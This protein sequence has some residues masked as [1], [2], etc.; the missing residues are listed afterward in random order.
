MEDRHENTSKGAR[1]PSW[2]DG[3]KIDEV[4]FCSDFLGRHPMKCVH[5]RLFTV[6]GAVEDEGGISR[7]I[8]EEVSGCLSSGISK[9][10]TNLL[11]A[12][13]LTAYSP[14]LPIE[15]DRIHVANGTYFLNGSFTE[16]KA[17][18]NNRLKVRY[19]PNAPKP[20]RWLGFLSELLEPEDIPTLQ[21]YLGY[22]LIPSTKGQKMLLLIGKG[23]EGKSRIGLVMRS[24]LGDSM[25]MTSIQKVENNRFSRADLENKLLMVDDDMDMAALPK[26]NYIKSIVTAE[27]KMDL[28]R[29]GVQSYQSRL[30][31]RFLCF[32]NGALTALHDRSDGFFRRQIVLTTRDRPVGRVD[33]PFLAEKL[34]DEAEGIFLWCLEGLN[35]LLANNYQFSLSGKAR[36]NVETV[37]RSSNNVIEFLR[38]E[39]YIRFRADA[40]ASSRAL[41][42]AYKLWC[43][44]NV[45]KPLSANRLSSEL[46]QNEALYKVEATNNIYAAGKRVRGFVGI[47][48]LARPSFLR[49]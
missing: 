21:E 11:A 23:G 46:A 17:W 48:V 32:G 31:A 45:R 24:L 9:A 28:E 7:M 42:E 14:P 15:T 25:N 49:R 18:C 16:D 40:E 41:Y 38:S 19:E 12:L 26:T 4:Q 20:E 34:A 5:G 47:E 22:C 30:Y 44:D 2:Y 36:E 13:K 1:L 27:C 10:V 3:K 37:K 6:D 29:K 33:D 35:R 8:L 43:E 39:G